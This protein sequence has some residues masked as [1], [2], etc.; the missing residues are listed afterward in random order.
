MT[1]I[2]SRLRTEEHSDEWLRERLD[3]MTQFLTEERREVLR[4]TL[5]QRTHYM[6]IMTENMFH[7]QNASAIM[8]HC[9]AFGIQQIHTVEDRCKFDPS[10]NI[11][12]GTQKW[13]DVEHHD[14]TK[15]ALEALKAEGY[16]IVA[17][18]PH[19]CSSTPETFD[20]TKGKFALV[21]GTEHAGISD[22]VIEA[23]DEFLMIPMCGM[24]ESLNVS[25][26]A[27]ILIYMLSERIRQQTDNWQLGDSEALKLLT[28]WT[29]SSVRDYERILRRG[30][31][32]GILK[33]KE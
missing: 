23:A 9:E 31:E 27:A 26:S 7:P 3:Y 8:R 19:R 17:T 21:F 10:V 15:E 5:S 4:R 1:N 28:R 2:A 11:V 24:V 29:M 33:I 32:E 18:T 22:E 13:V 14:T 20:V 16:R 30:E 6:R 25:A 12:R